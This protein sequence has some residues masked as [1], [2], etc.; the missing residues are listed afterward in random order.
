MLVI[1]FNY[2]GVAVPLSPSPAA[3]QT[4]ANNGEQRFFFRVCCMPQTQAQ[5]QQEAAQLEQ[6][7]HIACQLS[8]LPTP[9]TPFPSLYHPLLILLTAYH[10]LPSPWLLIYIPLTLQSCSRS[11]SAFPLPLLSLPLS[12]I[13]IFIACYMNMIS[14]SFLPFSARRIFLRIHV[15][16]CHKNAIKYCLVIWSESN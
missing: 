9:L 5:P 10:A 12:L 2:V 3:P 4:K 8:T 13:P 1:A 14:I 11:R 15:K 7:T 16:N 6:L